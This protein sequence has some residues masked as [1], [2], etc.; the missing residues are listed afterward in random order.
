MNDPITRRQLL[1]RAAVGGAAR[2][3]PALLAACGG[4]GGIEG[5]AEREPAHDGASSSELAD[6]APVS[7]W[8]YYIDTE[9]G[10]ERVP[11]PRGV[12]RG[13]GRQRQLPRGRQRRTRSS[14][15]KIQAPLSQGQSIDRD[16][17][18]P[19]RLDG[20]AAWLR[21]G[22]V[23]KLDKS[24]IPN[25]SNLVETLRNPAWDP[26]RDYSLP[27]QSVH[28]RHRLRP[29]EGRRR[30]SRRSRICSTPRSRARSRCSTAMED[31]VGL[32]LLE[33]DVDPSG[34]IDPR[35]STGVAKVQKA[36]DT[37]RSANFTGN[38]YTGPL[39]K[40]DVLGVDRLVRR[41]HP[42]SSRTTRTS[43]SRSRTPA[44]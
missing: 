41:H 17:I 21:L 4:G 32:F 33:M 22:Y 37:G 43:S 12:H 9:R 10:R 36:V 44:G 5:Q 1:K 28:H 38:D 40:G 25:M 42:S 16:I 24:A 20:G 2:R 34:D 3:L 7:N 11:D 35:H 39:A 26:N 19:H 27:W 15:A 13:D 14:S 31:T 18:V 8:P 30:A 23:Q 6:D 29:G